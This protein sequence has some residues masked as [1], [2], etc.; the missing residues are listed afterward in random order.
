[1][2]KRPEGIEQCKI[3]IDGCFDF[4]HHGMCGR[5]RILVEG[6]QEPPSSRLGNRGY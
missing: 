1:M 4:A 3:W 2:Y 6:V 5:A